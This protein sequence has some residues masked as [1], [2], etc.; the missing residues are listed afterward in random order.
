[1]A[2]Y[3]WTNIEGNAKVFEYPSTRD[4]TSGGFHPTEKPIALYKWLLMNYAK[5]GDKVLDTHVGSA[6]SLIACID[7]GHPYL[8]FEIDEEYY[9]KAVA[10]IEEHEAQL[11]FF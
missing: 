1:M 9:K 6:S 2:E 3:A 7:M 4:E 5:P 10:R 8:G 11:R